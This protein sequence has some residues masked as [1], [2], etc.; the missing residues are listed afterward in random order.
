MAY[1]G[2]SYLGKVM[3]R[4]GFVIEFPNVSSMA[5][6]KQSNPP[7][8]YAESS[9]QQFPL[10]TKLIQGE[11][12]WRYCKAGGVG[13]NIGAPQQQA[14][15]IHAE[16]DDDIAVGAGFAIGVSTISLTST[17]NLAAAPLTTANGFAEGYVY[18]NIA[19]G[20]GQCYKIK[21]HDAFSGTDEEGVVLYD[22]L[23]IALTTSSKAG[24][25]QN[26]Y[27]N[28]IAT[29]AVVSGLCVGVPGLAITA[30]Y[31]FWIQTGGP[32]AVAINTTIAL[33]TEVVVGTTA[34]KGDPA[35]AAAT[36][37]PIGFCMTPGQTGGAD[38]ALVFLTLDR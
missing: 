29:E 21:S 37:I 26:P 18:F 1:N 10:G 14:K 16:A 38:H 6:L 20:L 11:R 4:S 25:I 33:G 13:L 17:S 30:T 22:A 19:A 35:A 2:Q 24:L 15:A 7:N 3:N 31:Y 8:P 5:N 32:A 36:E 27:A 34:A 12:V 28:V 9:E 23:T